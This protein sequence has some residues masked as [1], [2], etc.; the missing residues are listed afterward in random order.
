MSDNVLFY[1]KNYLAMNILQKILLCLLLMLYN[2]DAQA[3][4]NVY[5][6]RQGELI[7]HRPSESYIFGNNL[8]IYC[9]I[10]KPKYIIYLWQTVSLELDD[11]DSD[12]YVYYEGA[13]P[14]IVEKTACQ[15][16]IYCIGIDSKELY[17]VYLN[18]IRVDYWKVL[19]LFSGILLF[20]SANQLCKNVIFYY[21]CGITLGVCASFLILIYFLSRML[22][23]RPMM[24]GAAL[25]GWT[26]GVYI[27][28]V[29]LENMRTILINYKNYVFWY[30][31]IT[32]LISFI[33]C[34]RWGPVTDKRT[35][36]L[37]Q[38]TFQGIGLF[39][40]FYSSHFQEAS[41]ALVILI[42]LV[43]N[44]P[45]KWVSQS[46]TYWR[47][48]FPPKVCLL[49]N[50]EYYQQGVVET[51]KALEELK[52]YCSSPDCNQWKTVLKLKDVKRF[53]SFVEGTSHLS[54]EEI[55][56]YETSIQTTDMT[57]DEDAYTDEEQ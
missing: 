22:P 47:R 41:M 48:K 42:L 33:V 21:L 15:A 35:Q 44:F 24:Y 4:K 49:S 14:E 16:S 11:M 25:C 43:Y 5:N 40:V 56:E 55:L 3:P 13:T 39:F 46:K 18:V 54:D 6:L 2:V 34:Y 19:L 31:F 10:G 29:L 57:D 53:A 12:N 51:A 32:A 23:G 45:K 8:K 38:W 1:T 9:Y 37:I 17:R 28:Q 52:S 30:T 7:T 36:N 20:F 50:T 27:L 26:V